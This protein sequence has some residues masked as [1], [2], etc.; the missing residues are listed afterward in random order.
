MLN[1][2]ERREALKKAVCSIYGVKEQEL[3]SLSRRREIISARRMVLYFLRKHYGE[4]YMGIAK[5]FSMNHATVMHHVTQMKNFLEFDKEEMTNY[6]KVRDYVFEQN[7]EVTLS[8]ELDLLKKEKSL[9]DNR[10]EQIETELN[11][12]ENGN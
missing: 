1:S 5:M 7:S 8:E 2:I 4:T 11:L 10:L 6:I 9:L 3:F 12:L